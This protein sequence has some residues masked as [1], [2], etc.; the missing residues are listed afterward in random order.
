[1]ALERF[2]RRNR[3]TRGD[4][5]NSPAGL[6]LKCDDCNAQ[7]CVRSKPSECR[8]A[9]D[10]EPGLG[11][12]DGQC[13]AGF[14]PVYCCDSDVCPM[15]EQCQAM[16]GTRGRCGGDMGPSCRKRVE[17]VQ[18]VIERLVKRGARCEADADCVQVGTSTQCMGTCGA[19]V[20]GKV[21]VEQ[22]SLGELK[23]RFSR[24]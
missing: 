24:E 18:R 13:I 19:I 7:V 5:D 15:G 9:C 23:S 8:T 10:C 6:W 12:F 11:C 16:D 17:K 4:D 3:P 20:N 22:P 14:A 21:P 1:M 2:F